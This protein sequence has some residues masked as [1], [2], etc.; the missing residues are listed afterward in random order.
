MS[1]DINLSK[2]ITADHL[3]TAV[4]I[5]DDPM[6]REINKRYLEK[7]ARII[8]IETFSNGIDALE[9]LKSNAGSLVLLDVYMPRINGFT[10][11]ENIR[12][13]HISSDVII[14]T[15]AND[16]ASMEKALQL[17]ALDYL[18]K[19][20]E[21]ERFRQALDK[22]FYK[23]KMHQKMQSALSQKEADELFSTSMDCKNFISKDIKGIQTRT[24]EIIK[25]YLLS[26]A[27]YKFSGTELAKEIGLSRVT[28]HKYLNYLETQKFLNTEIDYETDGR[29]RLL[30]FTESTGEV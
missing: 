12:R 24:L 18:V 29:P 5:E 23:Q 17:G 14:V 28:V 8:N 16:F 13:E 19:P 3:N 30:Y 15:A 20:F 27:G 26:H 11:F 1:N 25:D 22:F 9:F 2:N 7:D 10:V 4:I 21:Y 6:V